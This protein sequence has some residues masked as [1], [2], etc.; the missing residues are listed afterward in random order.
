MRPKPYGVVAEFT[1][2]EQLLHAAQAAKDAGYRKMEGY[3]PIPVH[4][5]VEVLDFKDDRLGWAVF[6]AG[7]AGACGG[8][9]LQW[10]TSVGVR[11]GDGF[12]QHTGLNGYAHN[13]GGKPLFSL[14]AFI[15]VTFECTILLAG[16]TAAGAMFA[17]NGL[18]KPHQPI[19]NAECM[20][21]VTADRYV[22]C[23]EAT[24]P[25]YEEKEVVDFMVGLQPLQ[26]EVVKTS[27]GY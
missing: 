13:T 25:N 5:L 2:P 18:P 7:L 17:F 6:G 4:G 14:P 23:I 24:D 15:P 10:Y 21:R 8:M 12:I 11:F 20:T 16:L 1:S 26:V 19:L 3:S 22:L 27:E 9:F